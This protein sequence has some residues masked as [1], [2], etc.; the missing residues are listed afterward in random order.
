MARG[1]KLYERVA[2]IV[3]VSNPQVT[4]IDIFDSL[5]DTQDQICQ[6]L[7]CLEKSATITTDINGTASV[8]TGFLRLKRIVMPDGTQI[9]PKEL[10]VME[11]DLLQHLLFTNISNTIQYYKIWNGVITLFPTP[12]IQS[13]TMYYYGLPTTDISASVEPEV[14]YWMDDCIRFG[15]TADMLVQLGD[16]K[17]LPKAQYW[18][19]LY[20]EEVKRLLEVWRGT[21]TVSN[22][23]SYQDV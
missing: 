21:K 2:K 18:K 5:N 7:F 16:E 13:Y 19:Q 20:D 4:E 12:S 23:I 9:F 15:C 14:P 10:D 8:P 11:F 6:R 22:V 1:Q 3:G 17:S